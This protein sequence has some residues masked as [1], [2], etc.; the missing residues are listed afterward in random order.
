[1]TFG[2]S[3]RVGWLNVSN[4]PTTLGPSLPFRKVQADLDKL[5]AR[6]NGLP[7]RFTLIAGG[8]VSAALRARIVAYAMGLGIA[9]AE[10]WSGPELEERIRR[11]EPLLI[12]RFVEGV[13]FPESAD[14]LRSMSLDGQLE[15]AEILALMA[16]CFDR[17]AF[18]T[19]FMQE[20][21]IP[22]FKKAI[23]DTIEALNTGVRRL[24]DGTEIGRIPRRSHL[25]DPAKRAALARVVDL[26]VDLRAY[27]DEFTASGE[28]RQC[29]CGQP[30]CSVFF[31]DDRA[32]WVIDDARSRILSE[33]ARVGPGLVS[34]PRF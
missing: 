15:D 21:S 3:A 17:P 27:H 9:E 11:D 24:R 25:K 2:V 14:A 22:D 31:I 12:R 23:T 5:A 29:G 33:F 26:L 10:V 4:A 18:T 20:S 8:R 7:R 28:I 16:E 13:P 34:D 32:A 6:P 30:E 1:M 19:P